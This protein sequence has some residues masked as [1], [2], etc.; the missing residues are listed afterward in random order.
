MLTREEEPVMATAVLL[1]KEGKGFAAKAEDVSTCEGLV[2]SGHMRRIEDGYTLS[3]D[4]AA[5]LGI[6]A[7]RRAEAAQNN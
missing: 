3:D 2:E 1:A 6:N 4:F 7:A 5:A